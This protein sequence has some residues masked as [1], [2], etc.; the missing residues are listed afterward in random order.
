MVIEAS[1]VE[2]P[3]YP[4]SRSFQVD[5]AQLLFKCCTERQR[6]RNGTRNKTND[7]I[8]ETS[9]APPQTDRQY[10]AII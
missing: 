3:R 5:S 4:D 7:V 10:I 9:R 2:L 6:Q 8:V 1:D